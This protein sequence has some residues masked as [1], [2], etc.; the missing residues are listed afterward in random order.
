MSPQAAIYTWWRGPLEPKKADDLATQEARCRAFAEVS[1][2]NIALVF[3]DIT[4][5]SEADRP[6]LQR[7]HAA[8]W[9][10]AIDVVL[11]TTP[12]HL[13]RDFDRVA[14]LIE[15]A[16]DCD[17]RVEFLEAAPPHVNWVAQPSL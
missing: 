16:T 17:I 7:L 14:R 9:A 5:D 10:H 12:D 2:Y 1:G 11:V 8:I 13:Y 4:T 15:E 3:R 6:E